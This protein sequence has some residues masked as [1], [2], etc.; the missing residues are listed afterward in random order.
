MSLQDPKSPGPKAE[1]YTSRQI[2]RI[3]PTNGILFF[4]D[5]SQ[6][7][8]HIIIGA[9]GVHSICRSFVPRGK[10]QR[11]R[12]ERGVF[13]ALI[14]REKL[15]EEPKASKFIQNSGQAFCYN[16]GSRSLFV[17][18]TSDHENIGVKLL[19][20]D[21]KGFK[22]LCKD[23]R[24]PSSKLKLLRLAEGFPE[25]CVALLHTI[26]SGALQ[27][28]P[29]WDMDPLS[30]YHF[31]RLV[32]MGDAA[33]PMPPYCGQRVAMALEDA[34]ALGVLLEKNM[35]LEEIEDRFKLYSGTRSSRSAAVQ[36]FVRGLSEA[37]LWGGTSGFDGTSCLTSRTPDA[38]LLTLFSA[39]ALRTYI[40]GHDER[41][42]MGRTLGVWKMQQAFQRGL[43]ERDDRLSI[44]QKEIDGSGRKQ[45]VAKS[46]IQPIVPQTG[47]SWLSRL[48]PPKWQSAITSS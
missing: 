25:E 39:S 27:D 32:L 15:I 3:D 41:L 43:A 1:I 45:L 38:F 8:G 5:G 26:E 22:S 40:L 29:I 34:V 12:I 42:H 48:K 4:G 20:D 19:Y 36:Q 33:H 46:P 23:W 2:V 37:D 44:Q 6:A 16:L 35:K 11:F 31:Q 17:W 24:E 7:R 13:R 30:T 21:L 18:P 28:Q 47:R 14:P 9:D 10:T